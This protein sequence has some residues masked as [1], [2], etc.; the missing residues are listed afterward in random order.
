VRPERLAADAEQCAV[1]PRAPLFDKSARSGCTIERSASR[2]AFWFT[3]SRHA[4]LAE[5]RRRTAPVPCI[6]RARKSIVQSA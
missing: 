1:E 4:D 5:T 6:V 2:A 3:S